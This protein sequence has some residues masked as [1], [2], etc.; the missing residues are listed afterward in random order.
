M[1]RWVKITDPCWRPLA[2]HPMQCNIV[3]WDRCSRCARCWSGRCSVSTAILKR[4]TCLSGIYN[5]NH[6]KQFKYSMPT[7][8]KESNCRNLI[9]RF[10]VVTCALEGFSSGTQTKCRLT[11]IISPLE[12]CD[13]LLASR[14]VLIG[15]R[16]SKIV[17][18]YDTTFPPIPPRGVGGCL[19]EMTV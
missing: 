10:Y 1:L 5:H 11:S 14:C 3:Q 2:K 9:N 12:T 13:Y 7:G 15:P 17:E 6:K 18:T 4:R 19:E 8:R 16:P